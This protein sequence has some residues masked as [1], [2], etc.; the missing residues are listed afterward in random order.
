MSAEKEFSGTSNECERMRHEDFM[1]FVSDN[2][3]RVR[4]SLCDMGEFG[5]EHFCRSSHSTEFSRSFLWKAPQS[6]P[7]GS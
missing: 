4:K 3:E 7:F 6:R 5:R 1:K 2:E